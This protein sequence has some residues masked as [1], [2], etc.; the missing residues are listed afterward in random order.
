MRL[1]W[2]LWMIS[3][4]ACVNDSRQASKKDGMQS[5][6]VLLDGL[7]L[8]K[9]MREAD[10]VQ[11]LYYKDSTM[12]PERYSRYYTYFASRDTNLL[13]ALKRNLQQP[14]RTRDRWDSC[15]ST[16]KIHVFNQADPVKT[17]YYGLSDTCRY[18]YYI[19]DGIF[20]YFKPTDE[21]SRVLLVRKKEAGEPGG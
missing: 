16:G 14:Y 7:D 5:N 2:F 9:G 6:I 11:I 21:L 15:R 17:V 13:G 19:R 20:Y 8:I 3:F 12:D 1:V 10:S 18:L 4:V